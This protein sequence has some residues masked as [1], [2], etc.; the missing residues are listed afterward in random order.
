MRKILEK[1]EKSWRKLARSVKSTLTKAAP[2]ARKLW[3]AYGYYVSLGALLLLF[4]IAAY[5]YKND[6]EKANLSALQPSETPVAMTVSRAYEPPVPTPTPEPKLAFSMPVK[7]EIITAYSPEKLVW[8]STLSQWETHSAIDIAASA[9]TAVLASES[10]TITAAYKDALLGY[11]VE[12]THKD[13]YITRYASLGTLELAETGKKVTK[14]DIIGAVGSTAQSE[15]ETG[16][17]LHFAML[18]N[19]EAVEP[20]FE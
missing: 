4:G 18:L 11:T 15:A 12:I 9:G 19:G 7:G 14:G 20:T 10:G 5:S 6:G 16:A 8:N 2:R 17:H 3:D 1:I 13:G